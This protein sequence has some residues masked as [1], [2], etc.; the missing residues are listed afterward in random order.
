M[1]E[2]YSEDARKSIFYARYEA[3]LSGSTRIE[4]AHVLVGLLQ[5][6]G[7]LAQRVLGSP[8]KVDAVRQR[9]IKP[10]E[11]P[12]TTIDLPFSQQGKRVLAYAAEESERLNQQ[13]I[14]SGH[15]MIGLIREQHTPAAAI[16][17]EMGVTLDRLRQE[18]AR[19]HDVQDRA[20]RTP[21][22]DLATVLSRMRAGVADAPGRDYSIDLTALANE[23]QLDPLIGREAEI[24]RILQAL[25][26]RHRN[27]VALTGEPGVGKSA[28]V[29]GLAQRL[30]DWGTHP[31]LNT[32]RVLSIP[33]ALLSG[34][35]NYCEGAPILCVEGL[36]DLAVDKAVKVIGVLEAPVRRYDALVIAT[37][38][39]EGFRRLPDVMAGMFEVVELLPPTEAESVRILTGVKKRYEEF[40]AVLIAED[41]IP[42]AVTLSRR[43]RSHRVLPDRALDLLDNACAYARLEKKEQVT[44]AEVAN[45]AALDW[46]S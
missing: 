41:A 42:A 3:S 33:A 22:A 24:D 18:A 19:A 4:P 1:F 17:I 2:R 11:K 10:A 27:W 13:H 29:D 25:L 20:V 7:A 45:R 6:D 30:A 43:F 12:G 8:E 28:V 34:S 16:L 38:S 14:G 32:R 9:L 15:M 5:A 44:A 46:A 40:H 35:R 37:G 36:F 26:R 39:P 31:S 21:R 23:E